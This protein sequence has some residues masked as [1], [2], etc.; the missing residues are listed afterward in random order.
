MK[1]SPVNQIDNFLSSQ[2]FK[3]L[4]IS[5]EGTRYGPGVYCGDS[6]MVWG[7]NLGFLNDAD[8]RPA[9]DEAILNYTDTTTRKVAEELIWRKHVLLWCARNCLSVE[10]DFAEC[11]VSTGF[12]VEVMVKA[13]SF[14]NINRTYWLYDTFDGVP[15]EQ[16]DE[17]SPVGSGDVAQALKL[18]REKFAAYSNVKIVPG[19][20]PSTLSVDCPESLAF[21]HLDL[22]NTTAELETLMTLLPRMSEG[23][24]IVL[25]D[26]G[27]ARFRR[28]HLAEHKLFEALGFHVLELP[29]G[30]GLIQINKKISE[31]PSGLLEEAKKSS[32]DDLA[33][34]PS[35]NDQRQGDQPAW[36]DVSSAKEYLSDQIEAMQSLVSDAST[37]LSDDEKAQFSAVLSQAEQLKIKKNNKGADIT[38]V[39]NVQVESPH[40]V[41]GL[42]QVEIDR[43]THLLAGKKV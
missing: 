25:D 30:Q 18:V 43:M 39:A 36:D 23:A 38:Y 9:F 28:Q 41:R 34:W 1:I 7:R 14:Q 20:L 5:L 37:T 13:L 11:G 10:G 17:G 22:N 16:A 4:W 8:L 6:L 29:T 19:A 12:G 31:V 2:A 3:N 35:A 42:L 21:L 33:F 27:W 26:Y 32:S 40:L 15:A 24:Y